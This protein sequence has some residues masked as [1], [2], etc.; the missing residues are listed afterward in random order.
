MIAVCNGGT[1]SMVA[2]QMKQ[3]RLSNKW[4]FEWSQTDFLGHL[5][6]FVQLVRKSGPLM[7]DYKAS[8][9]RFSS[10]MDVKRCCQVSHLG[11][12]V[13]DKQAYQKLDGSWNRVA[14]DTSGCLH[15][16]VVPASGVSLE[17]VTLNIVIQYGRKASKAHLLLPLLTDT[18]LSRQPLMTLW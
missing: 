13:T 6:V 12:F 5:C 14:I 3:L 11:L 9:R 1:S 2:I 17:L 4:S 7:C 16:S 10:T 18:D 8:Y 15:L